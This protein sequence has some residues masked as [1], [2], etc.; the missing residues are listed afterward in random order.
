MKQQLS[1]LKFVLLGAVLLLSL[2]ACN[3][4][5]AEAIK[6][7][8]ERFRIEAITALD[9]IKALFSKSLSMPFEGEENQIKRIATDLESEASFDAEKLA[10]LIDESETGRSARQKVNDE[11]ERIAHELSLFLSGIRSF[12]VTVLS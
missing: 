1:Y 2:S 7:A 3:R 9:T 11:F 10:F 12:I 8:A 5:K 6:V 4:E